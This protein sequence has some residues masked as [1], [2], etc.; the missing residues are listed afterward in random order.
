MQLLRENR[1]D[2]LRCAREHG[3]RNVRIFGSLARGDADEASDVDFLAE[4]ERGRSLFDMGGLQ[5]ALEQM[6]GRS[7][8]LVSEKGLRERIRERVLGEARPL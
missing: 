3:A 7:V 1:E 2:I 4:M 8:D 5:F 6:L